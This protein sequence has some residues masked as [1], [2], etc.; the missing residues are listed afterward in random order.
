VGKV[1][2]FMISSDEKWK[3]PM[4]WMREARV[5][6]TLSELAN[7]LKDFTTFLSLSTIVSHLLLSVDLDDLNSTSLDI[8]P[9][10]MPLDREVFGG[11]GKALGVCKQESSIVTFKDSAANGG[12]DVIWQEDAPNDFNKEGTQWQESKHAGAKG[13]VLRL[14]GG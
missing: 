8:G 1:D 11:I 10:E 3:C 12:P 6:P 2:E 9:E 7:A 5:S 14:H 4:R 13:R